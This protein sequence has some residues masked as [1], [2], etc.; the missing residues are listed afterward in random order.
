MLKVDNVSNSKL[1]LFKCLIYTVWQTTNVS[2]FF[3]ETMNKVCFTN[4]NN[5]T[6]FLSERKRNAFN[7]NIKYTFSVLH[8]DLKWYR[9]LAIV[10]GL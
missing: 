8:V 4:D 2:E 5:L 9:M 10:V 6:A 3:W 7:W 1:I